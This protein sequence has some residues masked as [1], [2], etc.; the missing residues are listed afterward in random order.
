MFSRK[1]EDTFL[2]HKGSGH[3]FAQIIDASRAAFASLCL[4]GE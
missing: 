1:Q 3:V 4:C 2:L